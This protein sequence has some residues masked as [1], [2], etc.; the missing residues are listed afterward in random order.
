[1]KILIFG[2]SG[3]TGHELVK[4][5]LEQNHYVTAF[6]RDLSKLPLTHNNLK[7]VHGDVKDYAAVREG[8]KDQDA[9]LSVL[10]A[11]TPFKKDPILIKGV[12]NIIRSMQ[13]LNVKRFI[14]LSFIGVSESRKDA[15]FV[16]NHIL[17][18]LLHAAVADHE[19]KENLIKAS[20]LEWTI[21]RPPKLTNG[22]PKGTYRSGEDIKPKSLVPTLSRADLADFLLNQLTDKTFFGKAPRIMY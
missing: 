6:V 13:E 22:S 11:S 7:F 16:I 19:E 20:N 4:K 15:G 8:I 5:A 10:G 18:P 2:A 21:V 17:A 14:Y 12:K 3:A 9:V 1:M